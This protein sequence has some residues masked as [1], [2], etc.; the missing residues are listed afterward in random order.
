MSELKKV[1]V[2]TSKEIIKEVQD[3]IKGAQEQAL[4]DILLRIF[5]MK[6]DRLRW[7]ERRQN[8]IKKLEKIEIAAV[9]LYDGGIFEKQEQKQL[10]A[11]LSLMENEK[12]SM[13]RRY[14]VTNDIDD[15]S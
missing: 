3:T 11:Q 13:M 6:A 14:D 7:I 9:K 2:R 15:F 12:V 4:K 10:E 1:T 8:Q 5:K